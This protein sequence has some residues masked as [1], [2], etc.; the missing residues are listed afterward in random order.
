MM[1]AG[2]GGD[3]PESPSQVVLF[4]DEIAAVRAVLG[5]A[6]PEARVIAALSRCGG[7]TQ[8]AINALLD[9]SAYADDDGPKKASVKAEPDGCGRALGLVPVKVNAE[10]PEE[11]VGSQESVGSSAKVAKVK[12]ERFDLPHKVPSLMPHRAKVEKSAAAVAAGGGISLVPRPK[13]R[14]REDEA[15]SIDLTATHPVPYLNARP[16]RALPPKEVADVKMRDPPRP[17][18]I[19]PAPARELRMVVAPPEAEFGDFPV[20]PDWFLVG[21]S[22]VN[23][24]STNQG[25]RIM[26]AGEIV[27][28]SF[29]SYGRSYGGLKVSAKKKAVLAEIVRFSTK[30]AGEIGKLYPEWANCLVPLVNSS[31][32]KIQGKI[33]LPAMELR[34]MQ[35]VLLYVSFYIHNSVFTEGEVSSWNTGGP[36]TV[37]FAA[38]PLHQLFTLLKLK[39][40]NKGNHNCGDESTPILG[41]TFP[42]QGTDEQAISEAALN[43]IVGTAETF[44]LEEAEP[45][46]T[47]VSVLKPYQKQAL[48]WMSTLE[49]GKDAN[50]ATRTVDPCWSAYNIVDKRAPTVYVNLF[51]GQAT[52]QFPSV[53]ETARGGVAK[54]W[55]VLV[56]EGESVGKSWSTGRWA[57]LGSRACRA[58]C[59]AGR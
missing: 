24:L 3:W 17:K 6:F 30:R 4:A 31:K 20:E 44:N 53:T 57:M 38:N 9:D 33:V 59:S 54:G 15:E 10:P 39:A 14:P 46:S 22:Y 47:L 55:Q 34:L 40:S 35:D 45:P 43:K 48:F 16:I 32:V 1:V 29:P 51:T 50:E 52:M 56:G 26:D 37:D 23:G 41:Q 2:G 12:S 8:R 21:K 19:A 42:E 36:V 27:H 11:S 13:K 25:R 28:F 49:K 18:A 58:A 7:N 5:D